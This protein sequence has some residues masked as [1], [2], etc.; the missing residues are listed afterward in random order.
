MRAALVF[1]L[2]VTAA[3]PSPPARP[4]APTFE[5]HTGRATVVHRPLEAMVPIHGG[6]FTMGASAEVQNA[7]LELCREE[8]SARNRHQCVRDAV[9]SEGPQQRVFVSDF[10]ID[11]VEV[12]VASYRACVRAGA[13]AP[14]PLAL[15]DSRFIAPEFPITSVTYDEASDYCSWRGAR[16][17]TEAEWERAARGTD[18]R[19]YPWGNDADCARGN[20][21]N[22]EGEGMCPANPGRP[23]EV[24]RYGG[25][26]HDLAGNVWEWVADWYDA[27]YYRRAPTRDPRGPKRGQRRVV[28]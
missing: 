14:T 28:R 18:G 10:S 22:F 20:F 21:G 24:G 6:L 16:L 27:R 4:A 25:E 8:I 5:A 26:L 15:S 17:P 3:S 12:T 13:C 11:R 1:V 23:V 2:S 19:I 7:A 9:D